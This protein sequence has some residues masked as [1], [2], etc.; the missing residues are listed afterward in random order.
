MT[1]YNRLTDQAILNYKD[2]K[3]PH[4][5]AIEILLKGPEFVLPEGISFKDKDGHERKSSRLKWWADL[6]S[7]LYDQLEFGGAELDEAQIQILNQAAKP[8]QMDLEDKVIFVGHYWLTG[9]PKPLSDKV[10]CVD[11]SV[12]KSGKMTGYRYGGEE[13]IKQKN[14][15]WV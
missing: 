12:A 7:P 15:V 4:H 13:Y 6:A 8:D 3:H 14:Y 10:A 2:R 9:T 5:Q 1:E 11:Y